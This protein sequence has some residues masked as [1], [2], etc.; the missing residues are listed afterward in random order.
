L[1]LLAR[2]AD[3]DVDGLR[4]SAFNGSASRGDSRS[5]HAPSPYR[6]DMTQSRALRAGR[7]GALDAD[8]YFCDRTLGGEPPRQAFQPRAEFGGQQ[9]EHQVPGAAEVVEVAWVHQDAILYE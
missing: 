2:R 5:G 7:L 6:T 8:A 4:S 3:R 9:A 1:R